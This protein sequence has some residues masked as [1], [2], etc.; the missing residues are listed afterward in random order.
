MNILI[1][2][3]FSS[4][5]KGDA[6]ILRAV[7]ESFLRANPEAQLNI[8]TTETQGNIG[9]NTFYSFFYLGFYKVGNPIWKIFRTLYVLKASTI[10]AFFYG[11]GIR[12]DFLL[13]KELLRTFN[14]YIK[15]DAIVPVGGGYITGKNNIHG[16]LTVIFQLHAVLV[17]VLM[18]K[19]V[20]MYSQSIG[21]FGNALQKW[22]S[23]IVLSKV[24][25]I[26]LRED[27]SLETLR[28]I[29]VK[30]KI[31]IRSPDAAFAF[32]SQEKAN[33]KELLISRGVAFNKQI[34]GITVKHF[35]SEDKQKIYERSV[36]SFIMDLQKSGEYYVV[37]IPQVTSAEHNDD[38]RVVSRRVLG[39]LP[40]KENII[41]MEDELNDKQL[42]GI[43]E[44]LNFLVGTRMHSCIFTLTGVVPVLA[45]QYEYKTGGIMKDLGLYEWVM[46]MEE[47]REENL[48]EKFKELV[49][50]KES[51]LAQ[52]NSALPD[53]I[54]NS[55]RPAYDVVAYVRSKQVA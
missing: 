49:K 33:M 6:A 51:Y 32:R 3:V 12:L 30:E 50:N 19:A 22:A 53:Y 29:G 55:E 10:W 24:H 5:N 25:T 20:F 28:K 36:A 41:F 38:D 17:P 39:R 52:L 13:T 46:F 31:I 9:S 27:F 18:K 48:K 21:P 40:T 37:M 54:K 43:Y 16:T 35:L 7:E 45:I 15:A 2:H 8:V 11:L 1:T 23:K 47:V 42:K 14:A 26:Y 34:V 4:K 44:N